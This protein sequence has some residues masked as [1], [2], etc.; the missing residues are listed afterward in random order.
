MGIKSLDK[1]KEQV[2]LE[3]DFILEDYQEYQTRVSEEDGD[4][5]VEPLHTLVVT[6]EL[7]N[8]I[9]INMFNEKLV[10]LE[11]QPGYAIGQLRQAIDH[12]QLEVAESEMDKI[13]PKILFKLREEIVEDEMQLSEE[14]IKE[15]LELSMKLTTLDTRDYFKSNKQFHLEFIRRISTKV[16]N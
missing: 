10:F 8:F 6:L 14:D 11:C 3:D 7:K 16:S 9:R 13:K 4:E 1:A 5:I 12:K 2:E 15:T